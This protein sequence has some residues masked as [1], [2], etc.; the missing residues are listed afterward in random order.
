MFHSGWT[1]TCKTCNTRWD[2]GFFHNKKCPKCTSIWKQIGGLVGRIVRIALILGIPLALLYACNHDLGK[3]VASQA[4]R[5]IDTRT[6][7]TYGEGSYFS[8]I[9]ANSGKNYFTLLTDL[10]VYA[11]PI[12]SDKQGNSQKNMLLTKKSVR[13]GQAFKNG[14][15][16]WMP[17]EYYKGTS[18]RSGFIL[19]GTWE[20]LPWNKL[21][22]LSARALARK[23]FVD[24]VQANYA[25]D[26]KKPL[27]EEEQKARGISLFIDTLLDGG[28]LMYVKTS[29]KGAVDKA[30]SWFTDSRNV[31]IDV[32]QQDPDFKRTPLS[33]QPPAKKEK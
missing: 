28:T 18:M 17:V 12:A 33:G 5:T 11:K 8:E 7:Y 1:Y 2:F 9:K 29:D 23:H 27:S 20:R 10:P 13:L 4:V 22:I 15:D 14:K 19:L 21:D 31:D 25:T 24:Y 3:R 16:L 30:R 32:L 6:L 26:D